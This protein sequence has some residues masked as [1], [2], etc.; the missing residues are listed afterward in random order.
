[1]K[2]IFIRI[3]WYLFCSYNWISKITFFHIYPLES[4][5]LFHIRNNCHH[6][7]C[8]WGK[9]EGSLYIFLLHC[10][11]SNTSYMNKPK[12]TKSYLLLSRGESTNLRKK[13]SRD[14]S[15]TKGLSK[16]G[17]DT[18]LYA[19]PAA[20]PCRDSLLL[21]ADKDWMRSG[22][23]TRK[24]ASLMICLFFLSAANL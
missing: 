11:Y 19:N 15:W 7:S 9:Q 22:E 8:S 6:F 20:Q 18:W 5:I 12:E 14:R 24:R 23:I 1:M 16:A 13:S 2:Y 4:Q 3:N 10:Q 21:F 17:F